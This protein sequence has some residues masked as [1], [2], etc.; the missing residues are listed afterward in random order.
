MPARR[1]GHKGLP[2]LRTFR[3]KP[4]SPRHSRA[5]IHTLGKRQHV[6][7]FSPRNRRFAYV[8]RICHL[9]QR[10]AQ[11]A[12]VYELSDEDQISGRQ[13]VVQQDHQTSQACGDLV[14]LRLVHA[15]HDADQPTVTPVT[16]KKF[17]LTK[18]RASGTS[19]L[20]LFLLPR[21]IDR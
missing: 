17:A 21:E 19:F 18:I 6:G 15:I 9:F 14:I 12:N 16:G 11:L 1:G 10:H 5:K 3:A 20:L 13:P 2:L 8:E 4:Q 7:S